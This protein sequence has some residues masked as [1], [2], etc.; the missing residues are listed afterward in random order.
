V[1]GPAGLVAGTRFNA[2]DV[3]DPV[4]GLLT[5]QRETLRVDLAILPAVIE[6]GPASGD[7][8]IYAADAFLKFDDAGSR[9]GLL[10]LLVDTGGAPPAITGTGGP[11]VTFGGGLV[12]HSLVKGLSVS[13]EGYFQFGQAGTAV[14]A[15]VEADGFAFQAAV[16]YAFEGGATVGVSFIYLSGDGTAGDNRAGNFMSFEDVGEL[17]IVE[18]MLAGFDWDTNYYAA[19][20]RGQLP[21]SVLN[22]KDNLVLSL[23]YGFCR[24]AQPLG[25]AGALGHEIDVR[26]RFDVTRQVAIHAAAGVLLGSDLLSQAGTPPGNDDFAFVLVIGADFRY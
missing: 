21:L 13:G 7:E 10:V 26:A 19:R 1:D 16:D 3:L 4:G 25:A 22:A 9:L 6:A 8:V 17:L 5:W 24:S 18:D 23:V 11:V 2:P 12:L 14:A 20:V 15:S